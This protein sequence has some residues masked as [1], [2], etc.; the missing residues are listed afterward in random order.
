MTTKTTATEATPEVLMVDPADMPAGHEWL[1]IEQP[2]R[3]VIVAASTERGPAQ[4]L[5]IAR[6]A[7]K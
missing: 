1:V 5:Q 3:G 7:D 2:G 4:G 6:D